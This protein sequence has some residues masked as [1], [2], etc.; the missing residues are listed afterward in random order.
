MSFCVSPKFGKSAFNLL[1]VALLASAATGC[2]SDV[3]RF[4]G[5]LFSSGQDQM[6]TGSVPRRSMSGLQGDPVPQADM[7]GGGAMQPSYG[8]NNQAY[9]NQSYNQP[10]PASTG[11][12]RSNARMASAPVT[13]QRSELSAPTGAAPSAS[14]ERQEALAQPFPAS[15]SA[16]APRK[17]QA[18]PK[19]AAPDNLT[20]GSTPKASGWSSSNA[21]SV[22]VRPGESLA[23]LAR[24]YGVPEKEILRVN[25]M[26]SASAIQPGQTILIP[27]FNGGSNAAKSA[28]Q[29]ADLSKQGKAPEPYK[30]PEQNVAVLPG[31]NTVR[32]KSQVTADGA[33]GKVAAAGGKA[34][35]GAGS[36]TVKQGDSL[37]KIAKATGASVDAIKSAN[38]LQAS[39]I[40]IGQTLTI[41]GGSAGTDQMK[42]ASI[43]AK[44]A[45]PK[46]AAP[47]ATETASN[48]PAAYKAPAA[49]QTVDEVEK[50][51]DVASAAPEA[52]GIGKYRWPVRGAVI[53]AYGA[54]VNGSRNDGIDI[55][56]PQGTPIKAAENGVVIYAGNGLKEL[57]N[58]V[59]VRHDDGTV[60]VYGN[61][62]TLSVTRG[63]KIQRGQTVAVSGMSGN[64][65]QPQVHF[66]VRKDASPVNPI[67]FLE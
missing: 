23:V 37:A 59:L 15:P 29:T 50:K 46:A 55:S 6:T 7:Q 45:E 10:Y 20:T 60:T 40:R 3:S 19:L 54:N 39:S 9:N 30:A 66:E 44:A 43:P 33:M 35:A 52:T 41:P 36:Y 26:K 1:A 53:A 32:D 67:T 49:T 62:D 64:V 51:S 34:P 12:I 27:T 48:Q 4:S 21:P 65:K 57:G 14:R 17:M 18:A 16:S 24:R 58:T 31:A 8:N 63:Q 22:T 61:A 11:A 38:N 28:A 25:N 42:T 2:S 13:V 56:V 47:A 5:G